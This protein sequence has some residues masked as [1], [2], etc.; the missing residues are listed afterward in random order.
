M[1]DLTRQKVLDDK[2]KIARDI[3]NRRKEREMDERVR[4]IIEADIH[5]DPSNLNYGKA[6]YRLGELNLAGHENLLFPVKIIGRRKMFGKI[7]CEITPLSKIDDSLLG[8]PLGRRWVDRKF[9]ILSHD[10]E[11]KIYQQHI[12]EHDDDHD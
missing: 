10:N 5:K 2:E 7:Q 1:T 6:F 11:Y 9:L 12:E 8:A 4:K 3:E